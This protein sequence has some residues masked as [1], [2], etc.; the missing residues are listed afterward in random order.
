MARKDEIKTI[1]HLTQSSD[2]QSYLQ[3]FLPDE[4]LEWLHLGVGERALTLLQ[5]QTFKLDGVVIDLESFSDMGDESCHWQHL[6]PELSQG[7]RV[8]LPI[9]F[10]YSSTRK[11]AM[12][13]Q[14]LD[15]TASLLEKHYMSNCF[16]HRFPLKKR[17]ITNPRDH[18]SA[19]ARV[20]QRK[21]RGWLLF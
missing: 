1:L 9:L 6:S 12:Q 10:C 11:Q 14:V 17:V 15:T 18:S 7:G 19:P 4:S 20:C 16:P 21:K 5:D 2:W 13:I 3:R 8:N